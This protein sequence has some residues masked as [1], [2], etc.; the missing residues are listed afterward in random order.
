MNRGYSQ[1]IS[2]RRGHLCLWNVSDPLGHLLSIAS[3]VGVGYSGGIGRSGF[4]R[5][6]T[7]AKISRR[8]LG[9]RS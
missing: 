6:E 8:L 4:H 1:E 7:V 5:L 9:G 2:E 3:M